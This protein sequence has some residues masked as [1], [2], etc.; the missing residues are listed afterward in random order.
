MKAQVGNG[1]DEVVDTFRPFRDA[2]GE[3]LPQLAFAAD[4]GWPVA[5]L[6]DCSDGDVVVSLPGVYRTCAGCMTSL[7]G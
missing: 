5:G 1:R 4:A 3:C 2:L 6:V 7:L